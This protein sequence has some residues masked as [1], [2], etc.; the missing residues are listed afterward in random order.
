MKT[1]GASAILRWS[2]PV[3]TWEALRG[4][5]GGHAVVAVGAKTL[6]TPLVVDELKARRVRLARGG[7]GT[8]IADGTPVSDAPGSPGMGVAVQEM[9][10][11]AG[12]AV[13]GL[14]REK[15]GLEEWR[16]LG[17]TAAGW[18]WSL[19]CMVRA[20]GGRCVA[21]VRD[22]GLACCVA[23]KVGGVRAAAVA[24]PVQAKRVLEGFAANLLAVEA[25]GRTVHEL[26]GIVRAAAAFRGSVAAEAARVLQEVDGHAHR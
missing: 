23:G 9:E 15:I 14:L 21:F 1:E 16:P 24:T 13:A 4:V 5:L 8:S 20:R 25:A 11:L 22:A 17:K 26:K 7:E 19:G 2:A 3:L 18:A 10:G 6:V 12:A